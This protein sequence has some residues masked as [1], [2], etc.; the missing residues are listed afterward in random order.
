MKILDFIKKLQNL[1]RDYFTIAD[2]EKITGLSRP[3]L[4]VALSRFAAQ[5]VLIRLKRGIYALTG[6][7]L[8]IKKIANQ[9]YY[10]SYL[11]FESALS[12]YGILSQLPYVQTFATTKPPKRLTLGETEIEFRQLKKE[13]YFGYVL[14]DNIYI[15]E[16]E[17]ALLDQL[18]MVS[19]GKA[20]LE[21]K[22]LD[23]RTIKKSV[24]NEYAKQFPAGTQALA[25][26]IKQYLGTGAITLETGERLK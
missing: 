3:S 2:L 19:K 16:P 25:R 26:E 4:K 24:L 1:D 8:K 15:A 6:A 18:Y 12:Y 14:K 9:L 10:P 5:G 20:T 23:L 17:K 13:L 22:E 7:S 21:V 11:S